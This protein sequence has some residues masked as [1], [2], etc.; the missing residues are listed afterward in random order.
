M[1]KRYLRGNQ[2]HKSQTIQ[3]P[4]EPI[5]IYKILLRR[6]KIEGEPHKNQGWTQVFWKVSSSYSTSV[7]CHVTLGKLVYTAWQGLRFVW[8]VADVVAKEIHMPFQWWWGG[9]EMFEDTKGEI[10]SYKL[11]DKGY[12]CLKKGT[13]NDLQN[14]TQKTKVWAKQPHE[15]PGINSG[16][17]EG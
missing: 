14:T 10:R 12:N 3:W 8:P 11:K 6:L 15:D 9:Q 17:P 16:V 1:G 5:K 2:S 4:K 7:T 13:N